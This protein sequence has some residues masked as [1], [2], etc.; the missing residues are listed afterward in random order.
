MAVPKKPVT[1]Y[2][3]NGNSM[4]VNSDMLPYIDELNLSKKNPKAKETK[5]QE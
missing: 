4:K 2:K 3:K 1:V 5:T